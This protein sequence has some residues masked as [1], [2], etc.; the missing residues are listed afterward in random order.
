MK[1]TKSP[2]SIDDQIAR[3]KSRGLVIND[4]QKARHYLSNIS[5]YRLRAYTYPF[6]DNADPDHPF[7]QDVSFSEIIELYVFDRRLRVLLFGALEKIEIALRTKIINYFSLTYGSH[8]FEDMSLY[9]NQKFYISNM[10]SLN[11]EIKRSDETFI[12][13]YYNKYYN[14]VNPP[15]WM[16]LEVISFGLLSK[17]Y[18]NLKKVNEKQQIAKYFGINQVKIMESWVHAFAALRNICAHH[19]RIWN[20]RFTIKPTLPYKTDYSFIQN[21]NILDYKIYALLCCLVYCLRVISPGCSFPS[22]IKDLLRNNTRIDLKT[23]GFTSDWQSEPI[24]Q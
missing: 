3:L 21:R 23:M 22:D 13:H 8:W 10:K 17:L 2:L 16:T 14:P 20:R 1:Y 15:A 5:Y 18:K 11:E 4:E 24:W 7:V 6:Q 12:K 19:G 9:R